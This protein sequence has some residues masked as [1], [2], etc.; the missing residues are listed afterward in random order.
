MQHMLAADPIDTQH[1]LNA[2]RD[3]RNQPL[4]FSIGNDGNLWTIKADE[5]GANCSI[6]I[7]A[8]VEAGGKVDSFSVIQAT[9]GSAKIFLV[10]AATKAN[11]KASE[12]YV[13]APFAPADLNKAS[14]PLKLIPGTTKSD[15]TVQALHWMTSYKAV[16][17]VNK[18]ANIARI[19]VEPSKWEWYGDLRIPEHAIVAKYVCGG[20]LNAKYKGMFCLYDKE[21]RQS[22]IFTNADVGDQSRLYIDITV[23]ANAKISSMAPYEDKGGNTG[24]FLAG[25]GLWHIAKSDILAANPWE[26]AKREIS[27]VSSNVIFSGSSN[28]AVAQANTELSLWFSNKDHTLGYQRATNDGKLTGEPTPLIPSGAAI[29]YTAIL[30]HAIGSQSLLVVREKNKLTL[31]E[32]AKETDMWNSRE[33]VVTKPNALVE[34]DAFVSHVELRNVAT[35]QPLS[36]AKLFLQSEG[37]VSL[38]INGKENMVGSGTKNGIVV[39]TDGRGIL[40]IVQRSDDISAYKYTFT[41]ISNGDESDKILSPEGF[42]ADPSQKAQ[43]KLYTLNT[44][45]SLKKVG[46]TGSDEDL[47]KA[48]SAMKKLRDEVLK[49][50][51]T[52]STQKSTVA[53]TV[54]VA[55]FIS[56]TPRVMA[57]ASNAQ[58]FASNVKDKLMGAWEWVKRKWNEVT[59]WLVDK[60][61]GAWSFIVHIAGEVWQFVLDSAAAVAKAAVWLLE[62]VKAGI[63]AIVDFIKFLFNWKDIKATAKSISTMVNSFLDFGIEAADKYEPKVKDWID[64]ME[65]KLGK[66]L[67]LDLPGGLGD[68]KVTPEEAAEGETKTKD[69]T[70]PEANTGNYHLQQG[71]DTSMDTGEAVGSVFL[72]LYNEVLKPIFEGIENRT[73][74]F[75]QRFVELFK[76]EGSISVKNIMDFF[77]GGLLHAIIQTVKDVV[78]GVM[79]LGK[80]ILQGVKDIINSQID[81]FGIFGGLFKKLGIT[82][83]SWLDVLSIVVAIPVNIFAK[84]IT[85]ENP[86]RI[87]NF[88]AKAMVEGQLDEASA[89]AYNELAGYVEMTCAFFSALVKVLKVGSAELPVEPEAFSIISLAGDIIMLAVTYPYDKE[90]PGWEYRVSVWGVGLGNTV[91]KTVLQKAKVQWSLKLFAAAD[92]IFSLTSFGLV[93]AVHH[94]Q[95]TEQFVGRNGPVTA[96][97][98]SNSIYDLAE[99]MAASIGVMVIPAKP[100]SLAVI[101]A[102]A[103]GKAALSSGKAGIAIKNKSVNYVKPI[104]L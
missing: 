6:N 35:G 101:G 64:G 28:L 104:T 53:S 24:L 48:A 76:K 71:L 72:N 36:N 79:S 34:V 14:G 82:L 22:L 29:D 15:V 25:N 75:G 21:N 16:L 93:Q 41:D 85:G 78:V 65:E 51:K 23:P 5:R 44:V 87:Q 98:I 61:N 97:D 99:R 4:I 96:L 88:S 54:P 68:K 20:Q 73:E 95:L 94:F 55:G 90:S 50:L 86:K 57:V 66:A 102:T 70:S 7:S 69:T 18:D 49:D 19:V 33:L 3:E 1:H 62:K 103:F 37:W 38:L 58:N 39:E 63:K 9:D 74:E 13:I 77:A 60:V 17:D 45:E 10:F 100:I 84:I 12:L 8:A 27:L 52:P 40:T 43:D 67:K 31:M 11:Q 32:Q 81:I 47:G 56:G 83:P 89:L 92:V 2:V 80:V 42:T 30:D 59:H 26:E 91:L 46:A